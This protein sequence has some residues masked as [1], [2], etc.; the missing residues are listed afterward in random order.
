[1]PIMADSL[2]MITAWEKPGISGLKNHGIIALRIHS[3][4]WDD[5]T[6]P[7]PSNFLHRLALTPVQMDV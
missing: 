6:R 4:Y 1:M 7:P 3:G 2:R 5:N